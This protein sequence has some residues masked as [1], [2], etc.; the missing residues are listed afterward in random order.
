MKNFSGNFKLSNDP[1]VMK[2]TNENMIFCGSRLYTN[3][4]IGFV[5][6]NGVNTKI[7]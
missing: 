4:V 1:K 2:I 3:W 5:L 6:F 7:F